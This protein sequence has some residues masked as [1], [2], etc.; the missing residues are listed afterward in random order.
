M[1]DR[2][3]ILVKKSEKKEEEQVCFYTHWAGTELPAT[4]RSALIRGRG[5]WDDF[6]YL[7]RIIFCEMLKQGGED[8]DGLTGYGISQVPYDGDDR[9]IT[10]IFNSQ[11]IVLGNN[12]YSYE[13]YVA[14]ERAW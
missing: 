7:T 8:L 14:S 2:A 4:L 13:E 1:G 9:I 5:R 10:V 6:Q 11:E 3:N 12:K